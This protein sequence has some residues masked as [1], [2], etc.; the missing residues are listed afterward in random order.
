MCFERGTILYVGLYRYM[1]KCLTNIFLM[2]MISFFS[3]FLKNLIQACRCYL[4]G[5]AEIQR[6]KIVTELKASWLSNVWMVKSQEHCGWKVPEKSRLFAW[7][8]CYSLGMYKNVHY[9]DCN[10][11]IHIVVL[12]I[13]NYSA[14]YFGFNSKCLSELLVAHHIHAFCFYGNLLAVILGA[15][16]YVSIFHLCV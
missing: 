15:K 16:E 11:C 3:H 7:W 13:S 12:Y 6:I 14:N 5:T 2:W 1:K 8:C 10:T 9:C 4:I